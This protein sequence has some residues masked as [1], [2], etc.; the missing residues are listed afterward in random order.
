M[1]NESPKS[2]WGNL[3]IGVLTLTNIAC[4]CVAVYYRNKAVAE[5]L[6]HEQ[7][8]DK[9]VSAVAEGRTKGIDISKGGYE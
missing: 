6:Q 9:Y 5:H 8:K 3:L 4:A 7:I 2:S 1:N